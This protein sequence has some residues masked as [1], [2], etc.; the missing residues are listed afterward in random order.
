MGVTLLHLGIEPECKDAAD[1]HGQ[2]FTYLIT[3]NVINDD[4]R[5]IRAYS[6]GYPRSAHKKQSLKEYERKK[7]TREILS[8]NEF[9]MCDIAYEPNW[10]FVPAFKCIVGDGL[11]LHPLKT[12]FNTVLAKPHVG[13]DHDMGWWK[14]W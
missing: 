14:G 3:V 8:L 1:Y 2:N 5:R 9:V 7:R 13:C 12:L 4:E 10:M 11:V 6:A